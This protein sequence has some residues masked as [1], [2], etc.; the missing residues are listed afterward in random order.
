VIEISEE[1]SL[2]DLHDI[3]QTSVDFG[4]D[5][6]FSFYLAHTHTGEKHWLCEYEE[7][8]EL[9][10]FFL[11]TCLAEVFPTGRRRLFYLFDFGD[12]WTFEVRKARG[13]KPP[14]PTV[15]YPRVIERRGPDPVQYPVYE[16]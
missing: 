14:D 1:D 8:D 11:Q 13:S 15:E 7:W 3:I 6:A 16:Q 2:Y 4:R 12:H 9:E 5:H 10:G